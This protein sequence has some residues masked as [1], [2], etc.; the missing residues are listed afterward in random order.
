MGTGQ[1]NV[2]PTPTPAFAGMTPSHGAGDG[3]RPPDPVTPDPV[4]PD[5][6]TPDPVTPANAGVQQRTPHRPPTVW[7]PAFAG[8]T[9]GEVTGRHRDHRARTAS[10][11]KPAHRNDADLLSTPRRRV[12][13]PPNRRPP[14]TDDLLL[15]RHPAAPA[16]EP[17]ASRGPVRSTSASGSSTCCSRSSRSAST[18]RGRRCGGSSTS[19]ATRSSRGPGSTTTAGPPRSSRGAPSRSVPSCSTRSRTRCIPTPGSSSRSPSHSRCRGC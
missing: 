8:M 7:I 6:V 18:P 10:C 2:S 13:S 15:P 12:D 11:T 5:P 17:C 19:I 4:T 3:D 9:A 14:M 1:R 16:P